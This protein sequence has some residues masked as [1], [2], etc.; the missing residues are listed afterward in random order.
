MIKKLSFCKF[1]ESALQWFT[2]YVLFKDRAVDEMCTV[3]QE[4]RLKC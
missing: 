2:S 3:L 4:N 1:S